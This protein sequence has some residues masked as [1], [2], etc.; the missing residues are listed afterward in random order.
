MKKCYCCNQTKELNDFPKNK[1][2]KDGY[3]T[4]CK[5]CHKAQSSNRRKTKE[6]EIS[7]YR[8]QYYADHK[9]QE[10]AS[11]KNYVKTI[12]EK[13]KRHY[14][15]KCRFGISV[16]EYNEL[17]QKQQGVC[18]ICKLKPQ[19]SRN[20]AV[21]HD[22]KTGKIRGLLCH[23]CNTGLGLF[24]DDTEKLLSAVEYLQQKS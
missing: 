11:N 18:A 13:Q 12:T 16:K 1:A 9:E 15:L 4:A 8:K 7:T 2:R 6:K 19:S 24:Y 3:H 5:E 20:L 10:Q 17:L 21:D 23:K 22:H 14:Y